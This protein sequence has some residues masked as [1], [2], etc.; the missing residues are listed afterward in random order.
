MITTY[1]MRFSLTIATGCVLAPPPEGP[2]AVLRAPDHLPGTVPGPYTDRMQQPTLDLVAA[3]ARRVQRDGARPLVTWYQPSSGARIE[4]SAIT[5][6]NWVDKTVNLLGGLGADDQP[7]LGAPL[8][9]D[10]PGHWMSW[11]WAQAT[12]QLGGRLWVTD[13]AELSQV[14]V[15][16]VGPE[17]AYPVPGAETVACSLHPL[18]LGFTQTPTGVTDAAELLSE[19]DLHFATPAPVDQV[20]LTLKG[21][22][23][24]GS[25]LVSGEPIAGRVLVLGTDPD[26]VLGAW[27]AILLGGGS[28][29]LVDP[30]GDALEPGTLD[31]LV[32]QERVDIVW[33]NDPVE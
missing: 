33:S 1:R 23:R 24:L 26:A 25:E 20:W 5:W 31:P 7:L 27:A 9:A 15:A 6:A 16:V 8:L 14:D 4:F 10:H 32:E 13:R 11:V 17:D 30:E 29:V 18:G 12:W 19:P 3:L 28:L 21:E 22:D 2:G